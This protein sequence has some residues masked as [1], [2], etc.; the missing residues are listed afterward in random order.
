MRWGSI[1]TV[2]LL[3]SNTISVTKS[4]S[5]IVKP[6]VDLCINSR[7]FYPNLPKSNNPS[8]QKKSWDVG[9]EKRKETLS[10][11]RSGCNSPQGCCENNLSK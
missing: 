9:C 1:L 4:T 3:F 7:S 11:C 10:E 8:F 2:F 6:F 5:D